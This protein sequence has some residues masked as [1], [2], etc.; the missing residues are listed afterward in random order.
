MA[1]NG[2][3][4][5]WKKNIPCNFQRIGYIWRQIGQNIHGEKRTYRTTSNVSYIWRQTGQNMYGE[6]R[7]YQTISTVSCIWR[8]RGQNI[9]GRKRIC[10]TISKV[11]YIWRQMGQ[12]IYGG[13][14][15]CHTI[16]N[17]SDIWR[18]TGQNVYCEKRTYHIIFNVLYIWR[19]TGQNNLMY[20]QTLFSTQ[21]QHI[22]FGTLSL[23]TQI[24][25]LSLHFLT[26]PR[27]PQSFI[28][29]SSYFFLVR[30][31]RSDFAFASPVLQIAREW[32][33][34]T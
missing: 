32:L 21:I 25:S 1:R 6:K 5:V 28:I 2:A 30:E 26:P 10:H 22:R 29:L 9:Y 8:Q 4:Y 7:T 31:A 11:S 27:H 18:Q 12:N 16:S 15:T 17:V 34:Q 20:G 19:Q 3:K 14:R 23:R 33:R 13:K 24:C